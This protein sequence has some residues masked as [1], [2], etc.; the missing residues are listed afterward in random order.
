MQ[1]LKCEKLLLL[2]ALNNCKM[3]VFGFQI[4]GQTKTSY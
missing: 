2:F 4:V 1:L 3:N